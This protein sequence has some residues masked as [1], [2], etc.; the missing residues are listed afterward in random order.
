MLFVA[1][2]RER[3]LARLVHCSEHEAPHGRAA[4]RVVAARPDG[5]LVRVGH[6]CLV[7]ADHL[8]QSRSASRGRRHLA[9]RAAPDDNMERLANVLRVGEARCEPAQVQRV[10]QRRRVA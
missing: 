7:T 3:R 1:A 4:A 10:S 8:A 5:A 6:S 2:M 9:V